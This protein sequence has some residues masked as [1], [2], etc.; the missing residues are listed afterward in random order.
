MAERKKKQQAPALSLQR[1]TAEKICALLSSKKAEDILI[2]DVAEKTTLCDYFVIASGHSSTQVRALCD[3]V[4][5]KLSEEGLEPRRT[6][7]TRE[8]RWGV[9]DYGDV[10]VHI[11]NDESRLF[12]HLERLWE[13]GGNATVYKDKD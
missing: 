5:E 3:H 8:G 13:D 10:I 11:F 4:E 7:G 6:E 9:L 2:I 12:Y 1:Q